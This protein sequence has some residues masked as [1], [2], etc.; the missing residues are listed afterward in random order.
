MVTPI[1]FGLAVVALI[2]LL[3]AV[4]ILKAIKMLAVN[5]VLGL[6]VLVGAN[7]LGANAAISAW[8]ILV[9]ALAGIPGAILVVL[10]AY[11]DIAFTATI[12]LA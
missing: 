1:E 9:C 6:V 5:A 2:A 12:V 3:F 8:S 11:L 4:R 7:F 10:L